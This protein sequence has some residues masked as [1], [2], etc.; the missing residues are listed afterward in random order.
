M[1]WILSLFFAL[2]GIQ[3]EPTPETCVDPVEVA[4]H[5]CVPEGEVPRTTPRVDGR[6]GPP[7][8]TAPQISNG[9]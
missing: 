2:L 8:G 4:A 3:E 1:T 7:P 5:A 6:S 9:F